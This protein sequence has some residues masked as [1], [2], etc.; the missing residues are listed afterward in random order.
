MEMARDGM[1]TNLLPQCRRRE[2][3]L[4]R[5][6]GVCQRV[7]GLPRPSATRK[8]RSSIRMFWTI[9]TARRKA[10]NWKCPRTDPKTHL[11]KPKHRGIL[12][13]RS[14]KGGPW[15]AVEGGSGDCRRTRAVQ[16]AGR[17]RDLAVRTFPNLPHPLTPSPTFAKNY[18]PITHLFPALRS[19]P[20][21]LTAL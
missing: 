12:R 17:C 3:Q 15:D 8:I 16:R 21:T 1:D 5:P 7:L 14:P 9:C 13:L 19:P 2:R 10:R 6:S 20:I 11:V 4:A 18:F